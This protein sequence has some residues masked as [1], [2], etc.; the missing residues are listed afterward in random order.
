MKSDRT[1]KRKFS[2]TLVSNQN[3]F[4]MLP[5]EIKLRKVAKQIPA[6][7]QKMP[8]TKIADLITETIGATQDFL[9]QLVSGVSLT[10][11]YIG[12][13]VLVSTSGL[14]VIRWLEG[15]RDSQKGWIPNYPVCGHIKH[16][17][18][19]VPEYGRGC[20]TPMVK[21]QVNRSGD[22]FEDYLV[23]FSVF[24]KDDVQLL[25]RMIK[26]MGGAWTT[27]EEIYSIVPFT[28]TPLPDSSEKKVLRSKYKCQKYAEE[29]V[30]YLD[31]TNRSEI[32]ESDLILEFRAKSSEPM[33]EAVVAAIFL[34]DAFKYYR[35]FEVADKKDK[36]SIYELAL[37]QLLVPVAT[38]T[39]ANIIKISKIKSPAG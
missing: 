20:L 11:P 25:A 35:N 39:A 8:A 38:R 18:S 4:S 33:H 32:T 29:Y 21:M 37:N 23:E 31:S 15:T 26:D 27:F 10:N 24:G 19:L 7:E 22:D 36:D 13:D 2:T 14:D 5:A 12:K 30:K 28:S 34:L 1:K 9:V 6:Q 17:H 3:E 16:G